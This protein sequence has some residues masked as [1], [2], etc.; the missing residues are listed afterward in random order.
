MALDIHPIGSRVVVRP[1]TP[2]ETTASGIILPDAAKEKPQQGTVI[3][4]GPGR[5]LET[6]S[7]VALEV[8][9]GDTVLYSRYAGTEITLGGETVL[10]LDGERD[11]LAIL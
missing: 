9:P 4:T 6:G 5:T 3:A 8:A 2:E 1:I 11:I 10:V 7:L